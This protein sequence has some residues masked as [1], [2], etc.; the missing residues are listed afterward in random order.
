MF[1]KFNY[2]F[3]IWKKY[4]LNSFSTYLDS[5]FGA[6]VFL[7]GKLIRF[8]FFFGFLILLLSNTKNLGSFS[9]YQIAF[10]FLTFNLIDTLTQ[11][12]YREVYRFRSI[13]IEGRF[14]YVLLQPI[15]SLFRVLYGGADF[16]DLVMLIP[17]LAAIIYVAFRLPS[18]SLGN[19]ILY[20][21]LIVNS[22]IITTAFH[23]IT[24]AI[25][26]LTTT[27]D[28]TI[29]IY[30]DITSM[31]RIPLDIYKEPLRGL[32]TFIIPVGVIMTFPAKAIMGLLSIQGIIICFLTSAVFIYFSLRLWRYALTK[33]TSASS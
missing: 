27:V 24:L 23:I 7:T 6:V 26:I 33:Y 15:S 32:L 31:G 19:V 28:H 13:V 16:L 9:I 4:T 25:G 2:Y 12:L 3:N 17:I 11:L 21:L 18:L 29:M 30:R 20:I 8:F 22:L 14:D 10:F 1:S 5:R